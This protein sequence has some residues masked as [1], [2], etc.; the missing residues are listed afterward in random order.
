MMTPGVVNRAIVT[1]QGAFVC[2]SIWMDLPVKGDRWGGCGDL[3]DLT[4]D[5]VA[6]EGGRVGDAQLA[7]DA[8]AIA[9]DRGPGDGEDLGDLGG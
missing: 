3:L 9:A 2:R 1:N 7:H 6:Q 4:F 5:D 8:T